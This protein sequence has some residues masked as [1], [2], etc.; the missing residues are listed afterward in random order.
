MMEGR[1]HLIEAFLLI[2]DAPQIHDNLNGG[3]AYIDRLPHACGYNL[4]SRHHI[5]L[6]CLRIFRQQVYPACSARGLSRG[7]TLCICGT[8]LIAFSQ[9]RAIIIYYSGSGLLIAELD[10][11]SEF[12]ISASCTPEAERI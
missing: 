12:F 4:I 2:M 8:A 7:S 6:R 3:D 9:H 11:V 1:P 10:P 5:H